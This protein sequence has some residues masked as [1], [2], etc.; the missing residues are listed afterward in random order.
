MPA[1]R[2]TRFC[3]R[4]GWL[5]YDAAIPVGRRSAA[6]LRLSIPARLVTL[7]DTRRCILVDLSRTG[8]QIGMEAPLSIGDGAFLQIAGLDEFGFV[9]RRGV[10]PRGGTNGFEFENEL[11]D[12]QVLAIRRFSESFEADEQNNHRSEVR[13]WV[14]GAK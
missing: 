14:N 5:S 9:M 1:D 10:G 12:D 13:A 4:E 6:R 8:A 7:V 3:N 11:T 2:A